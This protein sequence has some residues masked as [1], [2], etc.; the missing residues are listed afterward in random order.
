MALS[1]PQPAVLTH[2]P[3]MYLPT[4]VSL[5]IY[6]L[7]EDRFNYGTVNYLSPLMIVTY[8][9][10]ILSAH[11]CVCQASRL[12]TW[13]VSGSLS[14]LSSVT[15]HFIS[16]P[17]GHSVAMSCTVALLT[18]INFP[19]FLRVLQRLVQYY[20]IPLKLY[21]L[22]KMLEVYLLGPLLSNV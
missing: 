17:T 8:Y 5:L 14:L 18:N 16:R 7:K 19:W 4:Q 20:E 1:S 3:Y 10:L 12:W 11:A 21:H 6:S 2:I 22:K 9:M 13:A 15:H